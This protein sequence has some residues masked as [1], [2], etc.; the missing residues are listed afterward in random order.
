MNDVLI[1]FDGSAGAMAAV[2]YVGRQFSGPAGVKVMLFYV[3]PQ[4]PPLLWDDGHILA[5]GEKKDR[6]RV[7]DRWASNQKTRMEGLFDEARKRLIKRG[8][9][10]A[11]IGRKIR[12]DFNNVADG[13]LD[14][15]R[16]GGYTTL[17]IGRCGASRVEHLLTGSVTAKILGRGAGLAICVVDQG[18]KAAG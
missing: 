10:A 7:I 11:R 9:K 8:V 1:A 17:V 12:L 6:Q 14:E 16:S 15:A 5:A 4:L 3:L 18:K 2:D 13:I